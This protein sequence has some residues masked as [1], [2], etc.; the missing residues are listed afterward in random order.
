VRAPAEATGYV[1]GLDAL[2]LGWTAVAMGAGRRRKEDAVDPTAGITL[3]KKPGDPVKPGDV[4]ARLHTRKTDRIPAFRDAVAQ[5]FTFSEA[6]VSP[7]S[8]LLNRYAGG[9][10]ANS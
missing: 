1:A 7:A 10:W 2:A 9:Q 3:N 6:P 4:L 5:A 8:R